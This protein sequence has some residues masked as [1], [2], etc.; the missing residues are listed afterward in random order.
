M[1]FESNNPNGDISY[2]KI[3]ASQKIWVSQNIRKL[4]AKN[5]KTYPHLGTR[6]KKRKARKPSRRRGE[7][8]T[9]LRTK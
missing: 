1:Y 2:P 3:M 9:I 4:P 8:H 5:P 7:V 6:T